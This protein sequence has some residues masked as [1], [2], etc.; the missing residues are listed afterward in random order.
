MPIYSSL[1]Y[2]QL[3]DDQFHTCRQTLAHHFKS[4][5]Q[6]LQTAFNDIRLHCIPTRQGSLFQFC[7]KFMD[8]IH[9]DLIGLSRLVF[10][11][12]TKAQLSYSQAWPDKF[13]LNRNTLPPGLASI[14][15]ILPIPSTSQLFT[16]LPLHFQGSIAQ[17]KY[18]FIIT[19]G[20][21]DYAFDWASRLLQ[22]SLNN[23][24]TGIHYETWRLCLTGNHLTIDLDYQ[25]RSIIPHEYDWTIYPRNSGV[26]SA[27]LAVQVLGLHSMFT[28]VNEDS[29][30]SF[31][32]MGLHMLRFYLNWAENVYDIYESTT[33]K[34]PHPN[35]HVYEAQ[36]ISYHNNN[37][38]LTTDPYHPQHALFDSTQNY[39]H[40]P[41]S[42]KEFNNSNLALYITIPEIKPTPKNRNAMDVD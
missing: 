5:N 21:A 24:E 3:N 13:L 23:P 14:P 11:N 32:D 18:V 36:P 2:P 17:L 4:L 20:L 38:T 37:Y 6:F 25:I 42:V 33:T 22:H 8:E 41:S 29:N 7:P 34:L 9:R 15:T 26:Q 27:T 10:I 28:L 16:G 31:R 40:Q 12:L 35:S 39:T 19:K 30:F 1:Y